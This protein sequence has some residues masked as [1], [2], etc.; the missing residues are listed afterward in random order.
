MRRLSHGGELDPVVQMGPH[1]DG[2]AVVDLA[3]EVADLSGLGRGEGA[4]LGTEGRIHPG[5][6]AL[7]L[8]FLQERH[9]FGDGRVQAL[10]VLPRRLDARELRQVA[11]AVL[12]ESERCMGSRQL[13]PHQRHLFLPGIGD[14]MHVAHVPRVVLPADPRAA[15]LRWGQQ[16]D[17][18]VE[19]VGGHPS[20]RDGQVQRLACAGH[21]LR[22]VL[23]VGLL[24][25]E[26]AETRYPEVVPVSGEVVAG[27]RQQLGNGADPLRQLGGVFGRQRVVVGPQIDPAVDRRPFVGGHVALCG[28]DACVEGRVVRPGAPDPV[29]EVETVHLGA[30]QI[31]VDLP[32]H[33][34][35]RGIQ[36]LQARAPGR[37]LGLLGRH[38]TG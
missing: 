6:H 15:R 7:D 17:P 19:L 37:K 27:P 33:R 13:A 36:R 38:G 31:P 3:E 12:L 5:L 30:Q 34:P 25:P 20:A 23:Q 10:I 29:F 22:E 2:V 1:H 21:P 18:V 26:G 14:E 35:I 28:V 8:A 9:V 24:G 16:L 32:G 11:V 4:V